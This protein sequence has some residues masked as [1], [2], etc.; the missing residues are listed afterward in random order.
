MR[1]RLVALAAACGVGVVCAAG[2]RGGGGNGAAPTADE[3]DE[4]ERESLAADAGPSAAAVEY[5]APGSSWDEEVVS[6]TRPTRLVG[7]GALAQLARARGETGAAA[8]V[9][10]ADTSITV[11]RAQAAPF[12]RATDKPVPATT[13]EPSASDRVVSARFTRH[14]RA[15][16]EAA[17]VRVLELRAKYRDGLIATLNGQE[18]ARRAIDPAADALAGARRPRGPE[19]ESFYVE[20][21]PGLLRD[22]DNLLVVEVR[23]YASRAAPA[24]DLELLGRGRARVVRGP[25]VQRI[26]DDRASILFETDVDVPA[27]VRW[28]AVAS[29]YDHHASTTG[30]RHVVVIDGLTVDQEVHYQVA[31]ADETTGDFSFHTAPRADEPLRFVVYGDVRSG[32]DTHAKILAAAEQEAPDLV[33][34]TGDMVLRGSDEADWQRYFLLCARLMARTPVYPAIGNHDLGAA[35]DGERRVGDLF[36]L[37]PAPPGRPG[38]ELWYAFDVANVHFVMLDSN[39]YDDDAQLKW[40]EQDLADA[41]ARGVRAIFA[42]AHHGPYSRGL[43][44]GSSIAAQKYAPLLVKAG[45][46]AFFSGHD[47]FYQR[48]EKNGLRYVVTG[49]GGSGLYQARCGVAGKPACKTND[50]M[51]ALFSEHHYVVVEVRRDDVRMCPRRPDGTALE[52]CLTFRAGD[53]DVR[54]RRRPSARP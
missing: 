53:R 52:K 45:V 4:P 35:G 20:V 24:F 23:P 6:A 40:L 34:T 3:E 54:A 7:G 49:G 29:R 12:G 44:G 33:I 36:E 50:G 21:A 8:T 16:R 51:K 17:G 31:T 39:H 42:V 47:H 18:I 32:H 26:G 37:P 5:V 15:G 2:G 14:F 9:P 41:N 11:A 1:R 38:A 19:W 25:I 46:G 10:V 28:G 48:G 43:H 27:E 22:G 13:I 30:R